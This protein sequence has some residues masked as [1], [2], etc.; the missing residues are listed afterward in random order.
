MGIGRH[1]GEPDDVGEVEAEW[2][3]SGISRGV[4]GYVR[5]K[6]LGMTGVPLDKGIR[7][8][9][10]GIEPVLELRLFPILWWANGAGAG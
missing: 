4:E 7:E 8:A 2:E 10:A 9:K 1:C 5:I 6:G 3:S